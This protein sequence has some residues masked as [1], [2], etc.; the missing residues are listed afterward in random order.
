MTS[1]TRPRRASPARASTTPSSS[2]RVTLAIRVSTLPRIGT[3]SRPSPSARIWATRRGEP[4]PITAPGG[5]SP[6]TMPSR[7]MRASRGSSRAGTAASVSPGTPAVGRS[8]YECTATSISPASRASRSA[9]TNTPTPS[10]AIGVPA[11]WLRSPSVEI[12]TTSTVAPAS[13][14]AEATMSVWVRASRL[15]RVPIRIVRASVPV[16]GGASVVSAVIAAPRDPGCRRPAPGRPRSPGSTLA[17]RVL[18]SVAASTAGVCGS[19]SN[20]SRSASA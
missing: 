4:V 17:V 15:A 19:S 5:S 2:P 6:S 9:V 8:L 16:M 7:A 3:S 12:V 18:D 10:I 1:P 20:S 13:V 11:A 14:S